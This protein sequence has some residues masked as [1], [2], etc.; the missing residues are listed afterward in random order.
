MHIPRLFVAIILPALALVGAETPALLSGIGQSAAETPLAAG[1]EAALSAKTALGA[2]SPKIVVVFA[3]RKF[4]VPELIQG[5]AASFDKALI[6]G[7]EGYSPITA[8]GNFADQG[9]TITHGVA[10]MALGG[11]A[12]VTVATDTVA[13]GKDKARFTASGARLA[14]GL[15]RDPAAPGAIIL[16]FGNQH[17]GD[18]QLL[19]DGLWPALGSQIHLLG[20]AAGGDA[21]KEIVRGEIV[22]GTNVA[23]L[24]QG[25]FT[26]GTGLAG[27]NKEQTVAKATEALT[28]A[29]A[30]KADKPADLVLVF[31]C[32][33]RRGTLVKAQQIAPEFAA[34][35]SATGESPLFGFYGGGEIGML[36]GKPTGVGYHVSAAALWNNV[37]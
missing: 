35:R 22:S 33:G 19:V 6:Y 17:V 27:G 32:G 21:A 13:T 12:T 24:I 36:D 16:S 26:V 23:L 2:T 1:T 11:S 10:V 34:I 18:N 31:D 30:G 28:A 7:C 4:L 37:R 9:H 3:S 5:V 20:V 8:A 15:V 29:Q 14:K 25:D